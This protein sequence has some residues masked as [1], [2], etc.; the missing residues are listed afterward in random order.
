MHQKVSLTEGAIAKALVGFAIPLILTS[1][2]QQLYNTADLLI[3]GRYAGKVAMAAVG[4]TGPI[5]QLIIGLF[6]GLSTGAG[7]VVAQNYGRRDYLK[8]ASAIETSFAL[9][10]GGGVILTL[11]AYIF[12]PLFLQWMST[13]ADIFQ[14]A[15]D[16]MRLFFIGIVPLLIYNMGSGVLRSM[17]D[18]TRPLYYLIVGAVVNIV[19]DLVFIAYFHMG[20]MGAG[21][22]TILGQVA[23]AILVWLNLRHGNDTFWLNY[24][25]IGLKKDSL[26]AILA[27]GVPAGLQTVVI[28]LSNVIIQTMINRFGSN[29]VAGGAA[30]SRIDGFVFLIV[31]SLSMAAMTFA[32]QNIGAGHYDRLKRGTWVSLGMVCVTTGILSVLLIVF[33][34]P[35]IAL[36]NT[37]PEVIEYGRISIVFLAPAYFIFGATEILGGILRGAGHAVM[38]MVVSI[39]FMCIFRIIWVFLVL[40]QYYS[41]KTVYLSY[42]ISWIMTLVVIGLY[43]IFGNWLPKENQ[44]D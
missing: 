20:V 11:V 4:A 24:K 26:N 28:N 13:P 21:I 10:I 5:T 37:T 31:A 44:E 39:L 2:L 27:I 34:N 33:C 17:G 40:P 43:F 3:V 1:I 8:M 22:A 35:L 25:N 12:T 9:A 18:S 30:A 6:V 41:I 7:V 23:S 38:P 15:V 29:A 14:D 19:L 42:P 32:G 16:Y 36:F